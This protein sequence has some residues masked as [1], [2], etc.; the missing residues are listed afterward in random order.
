MKFTKRSSLERET[1][2]Y[3][4]LSPGGAPCSRHSEQPPRRSDVGLFCCRPVWRDPRIEL[5]I[6]AAPKTHLDFRV[7][8]VVPK[9]SSA[10]MLTTMGG[11]VAGP[12]AWAV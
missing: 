1:H 12:P 9:S 8:A 7:D 4:P 5:S 10:S 3:L 6:I 2:H 11:V